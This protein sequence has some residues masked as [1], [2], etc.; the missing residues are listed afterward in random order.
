MQNKFRVKIKKNVN[1]HKYPM[2]SDEIIND[3][4]YFSFS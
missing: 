1:L 3:E 2:I 4:F